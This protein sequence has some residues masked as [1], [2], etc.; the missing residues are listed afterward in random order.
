MLLG[1]HAST[2]GGIATA[3]EGARRDGADCFQVFVTA[4]RQWKPRPLLAEDARAFRTALRAARLGPSAAHA[5]YLI[6]LAGPE[7][8]V[9]RRSL[10]LLAT[11]LARS[12]ALGIDYVIVHPG[13]HVGLGEARG[14]QQVAAALDGVLAAAPPGVTLLLENTAGQGDC[15][16][17]EFPHLRDMIGGCR[18]PRR[19]G[20]C[21]DTQ[22]AFAAG[23][24]LRTDAGYAAAFDAL[25]RAV[26][27]PKLKA[28]HLN[29]S[30]RPLGA[31]VDRHENIGL[32]HM[33][34][35]PFRK[36]VNDPRFA[37]TPAYLETPPFEGAPSFARNLG[38]LRSLRRRPG[39]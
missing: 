5:S 31:R 15:V 11:E 4:S 23:H 29:D 34:L 9:R 24:D 1:V 33:G 26:G 17:H 35:P 20:I 39:R 21:L 30:K 8:P 13:S 14:V 27:L 7:G 16:G 6:N 36:L 25:G 22:H 28:F 10:R 18:Y 37:G 12:A 38:I 2:S 32:G 19:V 3:L